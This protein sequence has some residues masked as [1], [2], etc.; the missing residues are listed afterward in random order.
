MTPPVRAPQQKWQKGGMWF[1][2]SEFSPMSTSWKH[3]PVATSGSNNSSSSLS[4][5]VPSDS[6]E[7]PTN[8]YLPSM[9]ETSGVGQ[10]HGDLFENALQ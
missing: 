9:T 4:S 2:T 8:R 3:A 10:Y 7:V 5:S 1:S 6:T